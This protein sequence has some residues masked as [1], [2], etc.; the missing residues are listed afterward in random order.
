MCVE[1]VRQGH[2]GGFVHPLAP[3]SAHSFFSPSSCPARSLVKKVLRP[4]LLS[5]RMLTTCPRC[6][7]LIILYDPI[8][9]T[10]V[11][12]G[13]LRRFCDNVIMML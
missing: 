13:M 7:A 12:G 9:G 3:A 6:E 10:V 4:Y 1:I 5:V 2:A 11:G 8:K